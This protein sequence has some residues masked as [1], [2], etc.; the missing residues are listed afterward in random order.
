MVADIRIEITKRRKRVV[1]TRNGHKGI[2]WGVRKCL[3]L[4]LSGSNKKY[5][6]LYLDLKIVYKN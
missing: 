2:Y 1:M 3:Y 6:I 4:R 5:C